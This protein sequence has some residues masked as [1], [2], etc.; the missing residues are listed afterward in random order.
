MK[1]ALVVSSTVEI[2]DDLMDAPRW[3]SILTDEAGLRHPVPIKLWVSARPKFFADLIDERKA[4]GYDM[5][6]D[7]YSTVEGRAKCGHRIIKAPIDE[8]M[9]PNIFGAELL[10]VLVAEHLGYDRLILCGFSKCQQSRRQWLSHRDRLAP[11]VR[12]MSGWTRETFGPP[13]D[14]K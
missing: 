14:W 5:G 2:W 10:A 6:F 7:A 11:I 4:T 12:S 1:S 3:E 9:I 13:E 8:P